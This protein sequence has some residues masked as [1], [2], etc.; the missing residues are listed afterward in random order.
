MEF[1]VD[2]PW[3]FDEKQ[4][5]VLNIIQ[6]VDLNTL[7]TINER[8]L[9]QQFTRNIGYIS[10][11]PVSLHVFIPKSA[12]VAGDKLPIQVIVSNN[13]RIHIDKIKFSMIKIIEYHSNVPVMAMK[14]EIQKILRKEA[15]GVNKK[16]EQRYEHVVDV[17]ITTPT[18]NFEVSQLIQIKYEIK[19]E[20]KIGGL[21]KNLIVTIPFKIGNVPINGTQPMPIPSILLPY[22]NNSP[23][24]SNH[25]PSIGFNFNRLSMTSNSS[26]RL[27]GSS[28]ASLTNSDSIQ[29]NRISSNQITDAESIV[30]ASLH[31]S[32]SSLNYV[33]ESLTSNQTSSVSSSAVPEEILARNTSTFQPS[34]PPPPELNSTLNISYIS[35][36]SSTFMDAPP[37][38]DEVFG[39]ATTSRTEIHTSSFSASARKS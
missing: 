35:T 7:R 2:R 17:P 25:M 9:E 33:G 16:T 14:R 15:G 29:S 3:K 21:H 28:T 11:G 27:I 12:Y 30:S 36:T 22:P 1:I 38:Y 20:A 39:T 4:Q 18:Q 6:L 24:Q 32:T 5:I 19:V 37:S 10:S 34:A 13:S 26:F 23:S 31:S 8:P